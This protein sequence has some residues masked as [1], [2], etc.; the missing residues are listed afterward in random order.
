[1]KR[2][3]PRSP[4]TNIRRSVDTGRLAS[5]ASRPGIDPR[6]WFSCAIVLDVAFDP[7]H[8]VFVDLQ[9][10]PTGELETAYLGSC[11]AGNRAGDYCPV[12]VDDLV[13]VAFPNG[14]SGNGPI[15]IGRFN[16][17]G[18]P[19]AAD[20]EDPDNEGEASKDRILRVEA[21]QKY[22]IRTSGDGDGIDMSVEGD[23]DF[24]LETAG[25]GKIKLQRDA[26]QPFMRG[27]DYADAQDDFLTGLK[28][29]VTAIQ[30]AGLDPQGGLLGATVVTAA[31]VFGPKI[32]TFKSART[33]YLSTKVEGT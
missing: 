31:G 6:I 7:E 21:G 11:Y 14:D 12:K 27:N 17:A 32:D 29:F 28:T 15:I 8:G 3:G 2:T 20:F 18:D 16:S 1:M 4:V 24:I 9:L 22:K 25:Q 10:Q 26:D 30:N 13:L 33:T 23:G 5:A 19:P